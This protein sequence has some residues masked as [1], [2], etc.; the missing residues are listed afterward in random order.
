MALYRLSISP[1]AAAELAELHDYIAADSAGNAA[2]MVG[3]ILDAINTL[4]LF[5]HR[6]VVANQR[7]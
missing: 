4:T 7:T 2:K 1:Q 5:L 6:T 3:R